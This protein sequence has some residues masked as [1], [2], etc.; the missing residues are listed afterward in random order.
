MGANLIQHIAVLIAMA[1]VGVPVFAAVHRLLLS[2]PEE[3]GIYRRWMRDAAQVGL[4][5]FAF[6]VL[7]AMGYLLF[8]LLT[9]R[10]SSA[11]DDSRSASHSTIEYKLSRQPIVPRPQ[12][13]PTMKP[14]RGSLDRPPRQ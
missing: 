4:V 14:Q 3:S 7:V 2:Q 11:E 10:Y 6:L 8:N 12:Q 1:V 13:K 5:I 9:G